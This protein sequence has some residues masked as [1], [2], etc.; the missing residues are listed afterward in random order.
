MFTLSGVANTSGVTVNGS[1]VTL[2]ANNL[3]GED[4]TIK[5]GNYQLAL[6][7]GV[8]A[9]EPINPHFDGNVYKSESNTAGY[10]LANNK[11]S[12]TAAKAASDLF[13]LN[14][15]ANTSGISVSGKTVTLNA[16][17]LGESDVTITGSGYTLALASGISA[18]KTTVANL[19]GN[20][21]TSESTSA[22]YTLAN[23]KVTY[24]AAVPA[25][26]F[27]ITNLSSGA[28]LG[29]NLIVTDGATTTFK[30]KA[31]ALAGK[32][33]SI[34]SNSAFSV[35]LDSN[36]DTTAEEIPAS[37]VLTGST[38]NYTATATG[39]FYSTSATGVI[40]NAKTGGE[41]FTLTG[42][43]NAGG[44]TIS[45]GTVTVGES[46]L[47]MTATASYSVA[48]SG[49][50]K[51]SLTF[52]GNTDGTEIPA[53]LVN[54]SY[55]SAYTPAHF[56]GSG[57]AYTFT[58]ATTPTIFT[59][60]GLGSGAKLGENVTVD[61]GTVKISSGAF[62]S[63]HDTISLTGTGYT[64]EVVD[65]LVETINF[66]QTG[67]S[68]TLSGTSAG[69]AKSG[70]AYDWQA[71]T[72]GET[73]TIT[74]LKSGAVLTESMFSR[75]NGKII[76]KP[77][78]N[79]LPENPSTITISSGGE[80]DT[81]SL[82]TT[83]KVDAHWNGF[84]YVADKTASSWT[85]G[86]SEVSYTAATGGGDL[87]TLS[88]VKTTEGVTVE[89]NVVTVPAANLNGETVTI[90][91]GDYELVL[92]GAAEPV[93]VPE[94]WVESE[95][96]F[97]Y[98]TAYI[99][100]AGYRGNEYV[101]AT[102]PK[103]LFELSGVKNTTGIS[104]SG[105][106]VTLN[107]G[108]LG[109]SDVTITGGD[110]QLAM[111]GVS[112]PVTTNA[113]FDGNVYKS[114]SNTAGYTLAD[115]QITYTAAVAAKDL[116]ELSG[117]KNTIGVAVS[118]STV[119]LTANNLK[120]ENVTIKGGDYQLAM[121]GVAAPT[122]TDAHF[123]GNV[124][125]SESNTAGYTLA[126]NQIT[127][128]AEVAAK[129][130]FELS[131]VTNTTGISVEG[132]TVT[133]TANNLGESDVTITGTGYTLAL[134]NVSEPKT[135]TA[136]LSGNIY[137]SASTAAGYTLKNNK[138]EYTAAVP[139]KTFTLTNLNSS[140]KLGENLLVTDGDTTNFKF[141]AS[142]LNKKS[143]TI[144]GG[145]FSV[146]LDGDVDTTAET[147]TESKVLTGSTLNYTAAATGEYYATTS[148]GVT[149]NA[150][151]GGETFTLTGI[152]NAGG[153]TVSGGTVT[154][155]ESALDMT[156][157]S[158]YSVA[159]SGDDKFSLTFKGKTDGT[160]IPATLVNGS[161]TSAYTPAHFTGSGKAYTFMPATIPTTFTISG[162]G[163]G[164]KLGENVKV[165][166]NTVKISSG[167]FTASHDKIS[168][169]GTGYTLEVV[170]SLVKTINF[171]Q[172]GNSVTLS[173]T[174]AGYAKSGNAY[175]WQAQTG[176][177]TLII[178]GL[179]SGATLT[180]SMFSR[181]NGK[182]IFKPTQNL[183]P[184]NPSTITISSGEIDTSAL[185]T[186]PAVDAHWSGFT[187][188]ADKT[189]SS[190]TSSASEVSYTA[191]TGGN[192]LFTLSG[193][194]NTTGI[195]IS[196]TTVTLNTGNLNAKDVTITSGYTL[197]LAEGISEPN[198][199]DAHF[200][201]NVYKSASNTA[202]YTLAENKVT[203][204]AA[205]SAKN[206][207]TLSGVKTT[208]GISVEGTTV[209]LTADNLNGK[210]VT[211][212]GTGYTL[213]LAE[214]ISTPTT[215][216]AHFEGNVYKSASNTAGYTLANNKISYTAAKA[217]T[218][219][220]EL[221]G[222]ANTTGISVSGKTV[223]LNAGNLNGEKVTISGSGYKLAL[224]SGISAPV[225]TAAGWGLSGT[226][227]T[228]KSEK[229]TAGYTLKNN[230]VSYVES[231]GGE[232]LATVTGVKSLDGIS[233]KNKV[234]T[235][236]AASLNQ[237]TVK[238][239]GEGYTLTLGK[240]VDKTSTTAAGWTLSD[241]TA[242]Y[243]SE[244][245]SAGY[246]LEGNQISYVKSSGGET[247]AT[248]SGVKSLDGISM[249]DKVI[250][251]SKA[252]LNGETVTVSKGYTLALGS[253]VAQTSTISAGWSLDGT[254]ATYRSKKITAG[255]KLA[256]NQISYVE[257]SGGETL[258]TVSGVKSLDG[259]SLNKKVIT[260][261]A[262]SLNKKNVTVSA[263][264]TLA[265]GKDVDK[266]A[267]MAP[268]WT[269]SKTSAT[270]HADTSAG[271]TLENGEIVYNAQQTGD[272]QVE[273]T[274]L[275]NNNAKL[276]PPV[277]KTL[278]L[279]ASA[280]GKKAALKSNAGNYAI[281]ISGD[282][283]GKTFTGTSGNDTLIIAEGNATLNGGDGD[284]KLTGGSGSDLFVFSGGSDTITNYT[285]GDRISISSGLGE[286]IF[287]IKNK[288]LILAYGAD[289]LTIVNGADKEIT[290]ADGSKKI[291]SSIGR[292]N[293]DKTALTLPAA[294]KTFTAANYPSLVT[295]NGSEVNST[296][297]VTGNANDN[298]I[299][300]GAGN[301]SLSGGAGADTLNGGAGDDKLTGGS[302]ADL[303]IFS[304][305]SDTI[306]DYAAGEDAIS[307]DSGLSGEGFAIDGRNVILSYGKD[308]LTI[309]D[310]VDKE[311]TFGKNSTAVYSAE[312]RFNE[313]KT[314]L[315]LSSAAETFN[316]E[317]Y[318]ELVTIKGAETVA[319]E[320]IGNE[321]NN[322]LNGGAGNDSLEG[323]DGNDKLYGNA[324]DD[325]LV[326]GEGKD[327]LSGGAGAD[328]LFGG[329]GNDCLNGGDGDDKLYGG[330]GND[331]S[332][333]GEGADLFIFSGGSDTITD[334]TPGE[335][336]I[337][338]MSDLGEG[339]FSI[340]DK[341]VI[342]AYGKNSLT[343][344][345]G[346]NKEIEFADGT[347]V[348][349]A[350]GKF[351]KAGTAITLAAETKSF[352]AGDYSKLVTVKGSD[353]AGTLKVTGNDKN[354][355]LVG[356]DNGT[357]L[358]GGAGNDKLFGGAGND[359]LT[360]GDG[361]DTLAGGAGS[362]K[363]F[364]GEG[365]DSLSGGAGNDTLTGGD[366]NDTLNGG[367][368]ND[369]FIGGNGADL[370]I[371]SGGKDTIADYVEGED[372][373]SV[374]GSLNSDGFS[375]IDKNVILSYEDSSLTIVNGLNK[376]LTFA[377]DST[378]VYAAGSL[379]KAET[380]IML[381]AETKS[382][383][384][385]DYSK[386][387]TI[388]GGDAAGTLKV[389]GNDKNN[390]IIGGENGSTLSGGAGNDKLY[391]GAGADSLVGGAGKDTLLGK[392][393]ADKLFGGD[394]ADSLS[395]GAGN[396]TL[397]G[398]NGDDTLHGGA[399]NDK[400]IGGS[401][402]DLF[403][404]S[405]G[406]DTVTDY[407]AGDRISVSGSLSSDGFEI[408]DK[409]VIVN[410]GNNSL[411]FVDGVGK[412][413]EFADGSTEI[414]EAG[415]FNAAGTSI[416]LAAETKSF[417]ATIYP[418]VATVDGSA[419]GGTLKLTGN[420]KDNYLVGGDGNDCISG[421]AGADTLW[422]GA[423]N[424]TLTGGAGDDVFIYKP[425]EGADKIVGY[426]S[427]ELIE[428]MDGEFSSAV[429]NK[430]TLTLSIGGGS[431]VLNK[432]TASTE[433]NINGETYHV[434]GKTIAK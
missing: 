309:V 12:Y 108:N 211:I 255:Y 50:S 293:D 367:L 312:G 280:L 354:N 19:N 123:D 273:I 69:Y 90:T 222:I 98:N 291:Y 81:S 91:G 64:L 153:V 190:W 430:N 257:E 427:G 331:K 310:G 61:K 268:S 16:G 33:V 302:G 178:T 28:K 122:T 304:G 60:S 228:Y 59:I 315:T 227:A 409:N 402:A 180:E 398:G 288:N 215:T 194:K 57:K 125:K 334:Y 179:K 277:G 212:T 379:N 149:Y 350:A 191:A 279:D 120:G 83:P 99:A 343:I 250:T 272:T 193:V 341:N 322:Y 157:S 406:K 338:I 147:I 106:T 329:A 17:N 324:G 219:L 372:K 175:E 348:V 187:Y 386:L 158:S 94:G 382:F 200:E 97:I 264:Y 156:A 383:S 298:Y 305:G 58:P 357:T 126:N 151:T 188:V 10:T 18:P 67:N 199:T 32:S 53:T 328:K 434:S 47:D 421:G 399:G 245:I 152:K 259:I 143:V 349:Y 159:L 9:P 2:T 11:V 314:A 246:A 392:D 414:Y 117:V 121:T 238:I 133:L 89:G 127:Y 49:D 54:G 356:G 171:A 320:I 154:V 317:N 371:F 300:G 3:K 195:L 405:G 285:A 136:S 176:G 263:G 183:L 269:V 364:G 216:D 85:T 407:A 243:K 70:S 181:A 79:L 424:D 103:V 132:N 244:K 313:A 115:N 275:F 221:S 118:G 130:L 307:V 403:I 43:K 204:K 297:K 21:Y 276:S 110:Y 26:T 253:N 361:H 267:T 4:V 207:F 170:D 353:A 283:S 102:E 107:A 378:S 281:S 14:G 239:S 233:L 173:G 71:Q 100:T 321:K 42:I 63:S 162:L 145:K 48:L 167:A 308:R 425:G 5:G 332:T 295:I 390:H 20:I 423:G 8:S 139:A 104:I 274:G 131:G 184:E 369:K 164:A 410:Y 355:Y 231:S 40:Y 62:T 363:L 66:A 146:D 35:E 129:D 128:T 172:S 134:N 96:K 95:G 13:T 45:G 23:N 6:A 256:N 374:S 113:H 242:T 346:F 166:G 318:P 270:L 258:I 76:F 254:T 337:S 411:T 294:T 384:A 223:T 432:V 388:K 352:D 428:I 189:A 417:S 142:A 327:T 391:G 286:G 261:S 65:S 249:D 336:R 235:I 416:T 163:S 41:T 29:E 351:N 112:A 311:I 72:G 389:T 202:G 208:D 404:F 290:F 234:V 284:D 177:E 260:V 174:S 226:T 220:F 339:T 306:T 375:I 22:G 376:T 366:G 7:A 400:L 86:A 362:D 169:T 39:E 140:A 359:S 408:V 92:S 52:N 88:G 289:T 262:D 247:L 232:T 397:N 385:E 73:L 56:T 401:G 114:E 137:T 80:I 203:Y 252:A 37:K 105:T 370:F 214:G 87:F 150:Q 38:L 206:L 358:S 345:D 101:P 44:V 93:S 1:T 377:D 368:G 229:I 119:T 237:N 335:D 160:E 196:G 141:K 230:Q 218:D 55:T 365:N 418:E 201:G 31:A 210:D 36:V 124:Y 197:A 15:V 299:I 373:I 319:Q 265:L 27:T 422:G 46:A 303:F 420:S 431:L 326:G 77:T 185:T 316:A 135:T 198:T 68:V 330:T 78:Q 394:D 213:A 236:S 396:D 360:G 84:T 296:L 51:F 209:T 240:D 395:G 224:A 412:E 387:V 429:F 34:T 340:V 433:F 287:S 381:A 266:P 24:A 413:I 325:K 217:E 30:F 192:D 155:N 75:S 138:V 241:S 380:S 161:Y 251:V 82:T 205:T 342:L 301:D 165:N 182:I 168:L 111:T 347:T 282:M 344:V 148:T 271:Y 419:A 323:G 393:G 426:E 109:E 74:G 248:V 225:T 333:G 278:T 186:T 415:K 144:S 25:K 292:F 116:F